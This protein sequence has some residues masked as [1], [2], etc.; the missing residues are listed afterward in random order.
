MPLTEYELE[1]EE[2]IRQN[3]LRMA[4]YGLKDTIEDINK[5]QQ[6]QKRRKETTRR[7]RERNQG[8]RSRPTEV[9][10]SGR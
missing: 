9:R 2:R 8:P 7:A 10:R 1:R 5:A 3:A 6:E 4:E